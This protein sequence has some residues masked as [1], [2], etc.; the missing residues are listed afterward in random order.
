VLW[1]NHLGH[2]NL[3]ARLGE[4]F[5]PMIAATALYFG[6]SLRLKIGSAREMLE[7]AMS[8]IRRQKT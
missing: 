8:R 4:V 2:A 3:F 7:L 6:L 5:V 1:Q